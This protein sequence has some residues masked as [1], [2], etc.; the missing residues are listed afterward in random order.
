MQATLLP[1]RRRKISPRSALIFMSLL[2]V[3]MIGAV[4]AVSYYILAAE[5]AGIHNT[6]KQQLTARARD[7]AA[8][9]T[10]WFGGLTRQA[11]QF[12]GSDPLRLFAAEVEEKGL[13]AAD[14]V[15]REK[16]ENS[17]NTDDDS[18]TALA[19]QALHI[20]RYLDDFVRT[21]GFQ[22]AWLADRQG[23]VYL[24]TETMPPR[25][26]DAFSAAL[27]A[28]ASQRIEVSSVRRQGDGLF[29]DVALP[30]F[31]PLYVDESGHRLVGVLTATRDVTAMLNSLTESAAGNGHTEAGYLLEMTDGM[32]HTLPGDGRPSTALPGWKLDAAGELPFAERRFP[33]EGGEGT[34]VYA[35]GV[36]VSELPWI[37]EEE[38]STEE[39]LAR[40]VA[41]RNTVLVSAALTLPAGALILVMLWWALLGRRDREVAG[42]LGRLYE[43]VNR[44]KQI[45]D[46]VNTT[47]LEGIVLNDLHGSI[48]YANFAFARMA[49]ENSDVVCDKTWN[50]IA[51]S[52]IGENLHRHVLAVQRAAVPQKFTEKLEIQGESRHYEISCV[53]FYAA[54]GIMT[55]VVSVYRDVTEERLA[56]EKHRR[57]VARTIKA[58]SNAVEAVDSYLLG[59][60]TF[61]GRL[62]AVLA[63]RLGLSEHAATL[64]TAAHLSQIGMI[65]LPHS[66]L[67]KTGP[68]T[69]EER[70][71]LQRHV[72]YADEA[73]EGIDFGLPV[74]HVIRSMYERLDG[75]GYPLGLRGEEIGQEARILAVANTFCALL[76]PRSYRTAC[77]LQEAVSILAAPAYDRQVVRALADFLESSDG[78]AFVA[79]LQG[80]GR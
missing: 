31:A 73:L 44:Q 5:Y 9:L 27:R 18:H 56:Q 41:F 3:L 6:L 66:L 24:G 13:P 57:M 67:T 71:Q 76:R 8:R 46:G 7:R 16:D 32:L 39:S 53:P 69:P 68:L 62:A 11:E 10:V 58:F 19:A 60:S 23:R 37:V 29:M 33:S 77:T 21:G 35:V 43:T 48:L 54:D 47:I 17:E 28:A 25:S 50:T 45:I 65:R 4:V 80:A 38:V 40:Y 61:V 64:E 63:E 55:G 78:R 42:E 36:P 79:E 59:H 70:A 12:A 15:R 74:Q 51:S 75:S 26:P 72:E 30:V 20:R 22:A 49:G 1:Q 34:A 52:R 2:L 14:M